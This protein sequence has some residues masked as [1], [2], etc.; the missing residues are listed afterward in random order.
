M[1]YTNQASSI[2]NGMN[3]FDSNHPAAPGNIED[4]NS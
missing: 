2:I 1:E 4:L 3:C